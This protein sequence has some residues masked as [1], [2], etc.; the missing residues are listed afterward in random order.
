MRPLPSMRRPMR[1]CLCLLAGGLLAACQSLDMPL[2]VTPLDYGAAPA[3]TLVSRHDLPF[4]LARMAQDDGQAAV[5][6][7]QPP[8]EKPLPV[9]V[10][11]LPRPGGKRHVSI[12]RLALPRDKDEQGEVAIAALEYLYALAMRQDPE[13]R[14]CL[15]GAGQRCDAVA[16]AHSHSHAGLLR[17]LAREYQHDVARA[18]R[19]ASS[20]PWDVVTLAST[21]MTHADPDQVS[22]RVTLG[23][24]PLEGRAIF[25]N[26]APHASCV[27]N[28]DREGI[29]TCHLVDQHG[30]G[31]DHPAHGKAAVLATFPGD[32]GARRVLLPTTLVQ[33]PDP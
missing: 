32:V 23:Q 10:M 33:K 18:G 3:S 14:Y 17:E 26:Q 28:S 16:S 15:V 4:R 21:G 12:E 7:F 29:A 9:A 27:A 13:A 20:R 1:A 11:S 2:P 30:D 6:A 8:G 25:F 24:E 5:L 19:A 22:V 31:D